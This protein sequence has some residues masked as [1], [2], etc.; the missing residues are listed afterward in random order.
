MFFTGQQP[1]IIS[2]KPGTCTQYVLLRQL[3]ENK[4][5]T[6]TGKQLVYKYF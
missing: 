1:V 3:L 2:A 6:D 4:V 5:V